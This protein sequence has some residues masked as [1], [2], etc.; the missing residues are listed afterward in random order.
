MKKHIFVLLFPVLGLL[1]LPARGHDPHEHGVARLDVALEGQRLS[2]ELD[3][4]LANFLSFEHA[5]RTDAQRNEVRAMAAKLRGAEAL[6]VPPKAALCRL[7]SVEL[8]SD[9]LPKDLLAPAGAPATGQLPEDNDSH[10]DIEAEYVFL[11]D[12]P[13][14]VTQIEIR[15]FKAF[16]ALREIAAQIAVPGKQRAAE[17]TPESSALE[18]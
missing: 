11:C 2:L 5:P 4:P 10:G 18:W 12:K 1:A 9:N 16:P 3:S 7:A 17:L 13:E 6:F 15:L 14:A 8:A